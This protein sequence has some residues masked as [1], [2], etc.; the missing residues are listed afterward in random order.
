MNVH[1]IHLSQFLWFIS[2]L[3]EKS[4]KVYKEQKSYISKL[5]RKE[6]KMYFNSL[7]PSVLLDNQKFWKTL[8]PLFSS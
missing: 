7:N 1:F 4:L 2:S 3:T 6:R 8:K 5:Y